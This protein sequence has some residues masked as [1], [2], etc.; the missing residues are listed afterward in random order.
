MNIPDVQD[1]SHRNCIDRLGD[2]REAAMPDYF[3]ISSR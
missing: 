3:V 1:W 2:S